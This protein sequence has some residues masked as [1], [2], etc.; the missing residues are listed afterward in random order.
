MTSSATTQ[1]LHNRAVEETVFNYFKVIPAY[2][3]F[4]NSCTTHFLTEHRNF[5]NFIFLKEKYFTF[6]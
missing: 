6:R 3:L 2:F 1:V 5:K 4:V